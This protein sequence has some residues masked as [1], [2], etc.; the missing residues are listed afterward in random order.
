MLETRQVPDPLVDNPFTGLQDPSV[1][2]PSECK[3]KLG[4]EYWRGELNHP[5]I[6]P[7]H[8]PLAQ[9]GHL[10]I[11]N[12]LTR[13]AFTKFPTPH[14]PQMYRDQIESKCPNACFLN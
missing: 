10:D 11:T 1:L 2:V 12:M 4:N 14:L 7:C 6:P 5:F 9:Q 3:P 8:D 13:M